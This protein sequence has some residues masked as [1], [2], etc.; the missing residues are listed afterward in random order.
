MKR[1]NALF[2]GLVVFWLLAVGDLLGGSYNIEKFTIATDD[3]DTMGLRA[4]ADYV[5]YRDMMSS[6]LYGYD[7]VGREEFTKFEFAIFASFSFSTVLPAV[8]GTAELV[9]GFRWL[10]KMKPGW[11]LRSSKANIIFFFTLGWLMLALMLA[12][13]RYFFPFMW[14]SVYFI[15]EPINVWRGNRSLA[16][17]VDRGNW[18]PVYSLWLGA[19]ICGFFWELWNFYSYPKWVYHIPFVDFGHVF[20]MP[21]LG[22]GGYL[23]F[24][25]ELY[26][27]YHFMMGLTGRKKNWLY[28]DLS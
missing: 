26:A 1:H 10:R 20:E 7:L 16:A 4:D 2:M 14:L 28:L 22:Y 8:L 25:M 9:N 19:L 18:R 24:G 3:I 5:I 17:F 21:I 12:W 11:Y 23:P 27:L 6:R 15:L 13:P